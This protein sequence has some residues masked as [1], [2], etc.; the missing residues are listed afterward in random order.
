MSHFYGTL[1]GQ[2]RTQATRRGSK[3]KP[4]TTI[5]AS[6]Q[7]AVTVEL[8]FNEKTGQDIAHV[9]L[10]PWHGQGTNKTLYLGPVGE[11][12]PI[13]TL[14]IPDAAYSLPPAL[15]MPERVRPE[16]ISHLEHNPSPQG[17]TLWQSSPLLIVT[18]AERNS[19][20][21]RST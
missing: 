12:Q 18:V 6:W 4:L 17:E 9:Y 20:N 19:G 3:N 2:A 11:Y 21:T 7:G 14:P 16:V 1:R 8:L 15:S 10:R 5:A 13:D